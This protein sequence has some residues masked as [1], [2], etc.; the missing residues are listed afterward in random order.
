MCYGSIEKKSQTLV[1]QVIVNFAFVSFP[2]D[3]CSVLNIV[4]N[5][6]ISVSEK[7]VMNNYTNKTW[8]SVW[9]GGYFGIKKF[10]YILVVIK[11]NISN[12]EN[13]T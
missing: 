2:T 7:L 6:S 11:M 10:Y 13:L 1:G 4:E 3:K 8:Q 12:S 9:E 5:S